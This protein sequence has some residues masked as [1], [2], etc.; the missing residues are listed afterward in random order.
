[1]GSIVAVSSSSVALP[2][3]LPIRPPPL[4]AIRYNPWRRT[5]PSGLRKGWTS[6]TRINCKLGIYEPLLEDGVGDIFNI[7]LYQEKS[8]RKELNKKKKIIFVNQ[9]KK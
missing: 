6:A 3:L 8:K 7:P 4:R 1:V 2:L 5:F 9:I